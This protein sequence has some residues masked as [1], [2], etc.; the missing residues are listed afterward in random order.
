MLGRFW[1]IP[2]AQG[3]APLRLVKTPSDDGPK[4]TF[5]RFQPVTSL[6]PAKLAEFAGRYESAELPHELELA[7]RDGKLWFALRGRAFDHTPLSPIRADVFV[8]GGFG[9]RFERNA[10]GAVKALFIDADRVRGVRFERR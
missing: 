5:T 8:F 9:V 7:V 6:P 4:V 2:E 1:P 3:K 10:R